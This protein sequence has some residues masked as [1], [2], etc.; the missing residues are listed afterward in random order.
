[1][2]TQR[3]IPQGPCRCCP[4]YQC[5]TKPHFPSGAGW[6]HASRIL[7]STLLLPFSKHI[8]WALASGVR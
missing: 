3:A 5:P 1:M 2:L 8:F 6:W 7:K 4:M